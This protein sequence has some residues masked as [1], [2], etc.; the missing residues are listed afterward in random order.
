MPNRGIDY[1]DQDSSFVLPSVVYS[2][3]S[4]SVWAG[5]GLIGKPLAVGT[6]QPAWPLP[7]KFLTDRVEIPDSSSDD[8]G[9]PKAPDVRLRELKQ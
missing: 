7:M 9:L 8:I 6:T 1:A 4:R 2:K 3:S 5:D